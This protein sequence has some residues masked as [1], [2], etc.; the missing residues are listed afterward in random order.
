[1]W[2]LLADLLSQAQL[3][4]TIIFNDSLFTVSA[5]AVT[6]HVKDLKTGEITETSESFE[7]SG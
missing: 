6:K 7:M 4:C 2:G 5:V 1:M 3:K